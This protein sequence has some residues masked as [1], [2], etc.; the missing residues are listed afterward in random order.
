MEWNTPVGLTDATGGDALMRVAALREVGPW[1]EGMISGEEPE[2]GLRLRRAGW[3]IRRIPCDMTRHDV[4]L[5]SF[6]PWWRRHKR[7]GYAYTQGM[8]I[9]WGSAERHNVKKVR[10]F[11]FWG[12]GLPLGVLLSAPWWPLGTAAGCG[13][14]ALYLW[15]WW[16]V[17]AWRVG[18]GDRQADASVY[19]AF[20]VIGSFAEAAGM[21]Q[22]FFELATGRRARYQAFDYK[23]DPS[24]PTTS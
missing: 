2:L 7:G 1:H 23:G 4:A 6:R 9:H 11:A 3:R 18:L 13:G 24:A 17:R 22:C 16:R 12:L 19:A 5:H 15:L 10:G 14:L 20:I 21:L 8:A